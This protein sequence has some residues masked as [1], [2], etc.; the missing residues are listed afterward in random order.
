MFSK[1][2][3]IYVFLRWLAL[4]GIAGALLQYLLCDIFGFLTIPA[5][6]LNQFILACGFW[7]VDKIIFKQYLFKDGGKK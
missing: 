3:F 1:E 5:F 6:L 7:F 4:A 2:W